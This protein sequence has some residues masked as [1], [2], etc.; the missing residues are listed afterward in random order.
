MKFKEIK[1]LLEEKV[2]IY[3]IKNTITEKCYI[4]SC[5]SF[6]DRLSR[7]YYYLKN[8]KHHSKKLQNSWNKYGEDVFEIEIIEIIE[9]ND[10]LNLFTR[11]E[12]YISEFNSFKNGYNMTDKCIEVKNF[13]QSDEAIENFKK[14]RSKEVISIDR[15]TG[16]IDLKFDSITDAAKFYGAQTTNISAVCKH[17]LRY[18]KDKVFV[19]ATE[20][21]STKDYKVIEHHN[22]NVPKSEETKMKMRDSKK[23]H[24][25]YKY[26]SNNELIQEF[27]SVSYCEQCEGFK[28][29][30]LRYKLDK[31]LPSGFLYSKQIKDIV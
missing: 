12:F 14:A 30:T 24:K 28:K 5:I 8:N 16:E 26:D 19:Y 7:H 1:N 10:K 21:D 15:F 20:Y 22:K 23:S 18:T 9:T 31:L 3:C 29:D 13:T 27:V 2:G 6:K 11:E 17:N 25:V 4:G